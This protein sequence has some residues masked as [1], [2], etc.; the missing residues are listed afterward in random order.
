MQHLWIYAARQKCNVGGQGM[1]NVAICNQLKTA[2]PAQKVSE[3]FK[4]NL[5]I[6]F[7]HP[8]H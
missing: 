5:F 8:D 4:S 6:I 1:F 2:R 7:H 3:T